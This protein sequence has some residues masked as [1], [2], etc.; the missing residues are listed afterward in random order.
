VSI[1]VR[2]PALS[3]LA[4]GRAADG[5]IAVD[6]DDL[7]PDNPL[8][9]RIGRDLRDCAAALATL[10]RVAANVSDLRSVDAPGQDSLASYRHALP[11]PR[12]ADT[13][14]RALDLTIR[15]RTTSVADGVVYLRHSG[16]GE[17]GPT[18]EVQVGAGAARTVSTTSIRQRPGRGIAPASMGIEWQAIGVLPAHDPAWSDAQQVDTST[19]DSVHGILVWGWT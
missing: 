14:D 13:E 18:R 8:S 4:A 2:Y 19:V 7:E 3:S 9:A 6:D 10:P 16:D 5:R 15:V 17:R 11:G 12:L 1:L